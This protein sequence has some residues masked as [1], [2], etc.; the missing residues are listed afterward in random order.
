M[1]LRPSAS[2]TMDPSPASPGASMPL[3]RRV[4]RVGPVLAL[5]LVLA[6]CAGD[7]PQDTFKPEGRYARISYDLIMPVFGIAAVVFFGV[8]IGTVVI[9]LKFRASDDEDFDDIPV[10]IHGHNTLEIGWTILPAL[11]LAVVAVFSV[12]A[13]FQLAEEPDSDLRIEVIGHQ[14]WWEYRYDVDGDGSFDGPDD[15]VTANDLVIPADVEIGLEIT[16]RDVIH[17]WWAP[18]LNG[19][20]DAVPNRWHP[21]NIHADEPGEY[22]G[23][24]TEFCGLS[25][26][27]MRI[28]VVALEPA[29][30]DRWLTEQQQDAPTF[31]EDDTSLEAEGY[32]VFTGQLCASCHLIEGVN[33]ENFSD[34]GLQEWERPIMGGK[35]TITDPELQ[36]SRHAPNLTHLFSRS[37][38]AGAK[39]NLRKSTE[40]CDGLGIDWAQDP[41]DFDRCF[42]RSAL[43]DWLRDP[44]A[45]KAMQPEAVEGRSTVRG[46]PDLG[47]S[48]EQ[49]DQLTAYLATLGRSNDE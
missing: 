36:A 1:S 42:D 12:A 26:A 40:Y 24:C 29:D 5:S 18:R 27:E 15:I 37:T 25:H 17:S 31:A 11:I 22:I 6:A 28:K 16:S 20:R 19:K 9:G 8:L 49:I 34:E 2:S 38:F 39:F 41:D 23:Q 45:H 13:I 3:L 32:R 35:G 33:D 30:F 4:R 46:M 14:W 43:E 44:P 7:A 48:E 47:L 21:W 10:Q